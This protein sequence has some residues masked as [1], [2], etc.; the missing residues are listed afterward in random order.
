MYPTMLARRFGSGG[1]TTGRPGCADVTAAASGSGAAV[2]SSANAKVGMSIARIRIA[3][4][5]IP[6]LLVRGQSSLKGSVRLHDLCLIAGRKLRQ[7][8][9]HVV[10]DEPR[11]GGRTGRQTCISEIEIGGERAHQEGV[12]VGIGTGVGEAHQV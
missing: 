6:S 9:R 1:P 11:V 12:N 10:D 5:M 8:V 7:D 2:P 4:L 3:A